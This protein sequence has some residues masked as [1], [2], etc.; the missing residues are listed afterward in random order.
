[1][2]LITGGSGMIGRALVEH[3]GRQGKKLRVQVRN[4]SAF[5]ASAPRLADNIEVRELDFSKAS[6]RDFTNITQ[7]CTQIIHTAALVHK[8]DAD[9]KEYELLNVRSTQQLAEA[10]CSADTFV[11]LSTI[12]VYGSG[13]LDNVSEDSPAKPTTPYAVSKLA[14]EKWLAAFNTFRRSIILRPALV[15]GENDRGNMIKLIK[16]IDSGR[17]FH[18]QPSAANKSMIY[19]RDLARLID[20]C[21]QQLPAGCHTYNAANPNSISVRALAD[22]IQ[23]NLQRSGNIPSFPAA[24]VRLGAR[25]AETM[26]GQKSPLTIERLEKLTANTTCSVDKIVAATGFRPEHSLEQS[27]QSEIAWARKSGILKN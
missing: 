15:F 26:L 20:D 6:E 9:Y 11:F 2:I 16:Q 7:D 24:L 1:M 17:Y 14:S 10:A 23:H 27:L 5:L 12:A 25:F 8:P 4:R 13:S 22:A 19:A 3:W 18:V 21:L